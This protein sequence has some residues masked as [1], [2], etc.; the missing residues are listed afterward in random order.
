MKAQKPTKIQPSPDALAGTADARSEY[1]R[2]DV[3]TIPADMVPDTVLA[4]SGCGAPNPGE[5]NPE[6]CNA[7]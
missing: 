6:D 5:G 3:D 4:T 1:V 7:T 2:P